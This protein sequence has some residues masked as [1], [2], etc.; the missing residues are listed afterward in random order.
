MPAAGRP[1][2]DPQQGGQHQ[3]SPDDLEAVEPANGERPEI[4]VGRL[5][6]QCTFRQSETGGSAKPGEV[7]TQT[8]P[9]QIHREVVDQ[10]RQQSDEPCS[11]T[12]LKHKERRRIR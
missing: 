7:K 9:Q 12:G 2:S 11:D 10:K 1:G 5:E 6:R 3:T 8:G 4:A